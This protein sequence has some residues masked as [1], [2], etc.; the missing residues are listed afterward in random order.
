[1]QHCPTCKGA[2]VVKSPSAITAEIYRKILA[3]TLDISGQ[4]VLIRVNPEMAAY[5]QEEEAEG[6]ETLQRRIQRKVTIQGAQA[7]HKDE[8]EI[9][10]R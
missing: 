9:I 2:G 5:F 6:L 1:M 8:Y 4:E 10:T 3:A 7:L